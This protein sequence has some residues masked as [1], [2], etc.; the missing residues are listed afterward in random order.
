M[1]LS[2]TAS[3]KS[4]ISKALLPRLTPVSDLPHGR[5]ITPDQNA[6]GDDLIEALDCRKVW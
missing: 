4:P 1:A 5:L 6:L 2:L 3:A